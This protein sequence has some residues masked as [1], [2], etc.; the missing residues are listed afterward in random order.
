M[1]EIVR[2]LTETHALILSGEPKGYG[3]LLGLLVSLFYLTAAYMLVGLVK[4]IIKGDIWEF[5]KNIEV[6]S[7]GAGLVAAAIIPTLAILIAYEVILRYAFNAPTSWAFEIS[8]MLMGIS[9]MLGL[10]WCTLVRKH[11][12]VD[13]LYDVL[14]NKGKASVDFFGYIFLL[15]P[16]L[17]WVTWALFVYFM[18]AYKVN[19]QSGESAWNPIIWPFKFSF[20]FGFYLFTMQSIAE[21]I[22]CALTLMGREVP[23]PVVPKG[24]H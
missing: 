1:E 6:V 22:K 2:V 15:L 7:T 13:F 10:A 4:S 3:W 16:I 24:I 23:D 21:T 5:I 14:P 11:I 9:L 19:E 20:A 17:I 18:E 8:Y 12:R